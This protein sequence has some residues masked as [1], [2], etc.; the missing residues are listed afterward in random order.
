[1]S[2]LEKASKLVTP[3]SSEARRLE[4]VSAKV[5][6]RLEKEFTDPEI[7]LGG[8]YARGTWLKGSLDIDYFLLYPWEFPREKLETEAVDSAI[9][10]L[11]GYKTNLR[12][13]EHPYVEAF[14]DN[15][16]VNV[17]PCYNV[18]QGEW[19]SAADRSPYHTKYIISKLDDRLRLEMRLFKKFVKASKVYGAEVKVQG[20]SG[21]VCE[22]LVLKFGS[23]TSVLEVLAKLKQNEVISIEPYDKELATSFKSPLVLLD[24]VDTTRNLG[25]AISGRNVARLVFQSRRFMKEPRLSYFSEKEGRLNP[26][27]E[28]L[29]R[30]LVVSFENN[31]RSPDILWG[32]LKKS[33]AAISNK[34]ESMGFQVLRNGAASDEISHSA[35]VFLLADVKIN[36]IFSREGPEYFRQ[37][38]L[39]NYFAKNRKRALHTWISEE[40]RVESL[41]QRESV[42]ATDA[43]AKLL[44]N[45]LDSVGA[46]EA[47][48]REIKSGFKVRTASALIKK[49]DWLGRALLSLVA[50][51]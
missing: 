41:F 27:K 2:V 30:T 46:S 3:S 14:V 38:E 12:Y 5:R 4:Q 1:M 31:Q 48:R 21:Y 9:R 33:A 23:F 44:S 25:A 51:E 47:I 34:L 11:E 19:Q 49:R 42:A 7:S 16:R 26:S 17:V 28:L 10:A 20:F 15:V 36:K 37:E 43:L 13:A 18:S 6:Q 35:L 29:S 24:P 8:S 45:K 39:E 40:G 50:E 32:E 22:I